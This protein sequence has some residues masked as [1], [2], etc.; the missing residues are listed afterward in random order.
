MLNALEIVEWTDEQGEKHETFALPNTSVNMANKLEE[1][2]TA[3][4]RNKVHKQ[5]MHGGS[6]ILMADM[7]YSDELEVRFKDGHLEGVE[8]WLPASAKDI[9]KSCGKMNSN[10]EYVIDPKDLS[11]Q[12]MDKIVG[13]RIPTDD[14]HSMLPLIVKGFLPP[15]MGSALVVSKEIIIMTGGDND[16]DKLYLFTHHYTMSKRGKMVKVQY[17][18]GHI[19]NDKWVGNLE[20]NNTLAQIENEIIDVCYKILTNDKISDKLFKPQDYEG[21]RDTAM[22]IQIINDKKANAFVR[23][24]YAKKYGKDAKIDFMNLDRTIM[25]KAYEL[26]NRDRSPI[27]PETYAY[28]HNQNSSGKAE[29]GIFA[30]NSA[31][32]AKLQDKGIMVKD[33]YVVTVNTRDIREVSPMFIY[34]EGKKMRVSDNCSELLGAAADTAKDPLL[35]RMG[36]TKNNAAFA[37]FMVRMGLTLKETGM[38]ISI[39]KKHGF[40][41]GFGKTVEK[42]RE[43]GVNPVIDTRML[44]KVLSTDPDKLNTGD[45]DVLNVLYALYNFKDLAYNLRQATIGMQ[46]DSP[47]H[48]LETDFASALYYKYAT[49]QANNLIRSPEFPFDFPKDER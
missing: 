12:D 4:Y 1:L 47:N 19:E 6:T 45:E 29:V 24:E 41:E 26:T 39:Y 7:K 22:M 46:A 18:S 32:N 27:Y 15:A 28:Y 34:A 33:K 44:E 5:K 42:L 3:V 23:E 16:V 10:G 48:A 31:L 43:S 20:S 14:K 38:L 36:I 35:A 9:L 11:R 49:I 13:Y 25:A 17:D 8:C 37:G 2:F 21:V 30:N 40:P